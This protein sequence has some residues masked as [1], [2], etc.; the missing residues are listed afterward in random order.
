MITVRRIAALTIFLFLVFH[1]KL[2]GKMIDTDEEQIRAARQSS[3]AAI[4]TK[5]TNLIARYWTADFHM[6]SSRNAEVSGLEMNRHLFATELFTKK[7][8]LYVRTTEKVIVNTK[9]NMASETGLWTGQWR[10]PDGLVKISGNYFAKWH[11]V[12]GSWKIRAEIYVP[13]HCN[14]SR[15]CE[16][17]VF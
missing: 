8:V 16:Q 7:E 5:D 10:E 6:I 17:Q 11:K 9:W 1:F 15:F 2:P 14:G 4:A 3:N 12:N 13:L